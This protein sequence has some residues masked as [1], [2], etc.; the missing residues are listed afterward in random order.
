M[1][2][3][4]KENAAWKG[5]TK[6]Q[7]LIWTGWF[8]SLTKLTHDVCESGKNILHSNCYDFPRDLLA[9]FHLSQVSRRYTLSQSVRTLRTVQVY[10]RMKSICLNRERRVDRCCEFR[11]IIMQAF[12]CSLSYIQFVSVDGFQNCLVIVWNWIN[13][14]SNH[15]FHRL[16]LQ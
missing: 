15:Y 16:L 8:V 14:F 12:Y 5:V 7:R 1:L 13:N 11:P 2:I 6:S 9:L 3:V 4:Y 10:K